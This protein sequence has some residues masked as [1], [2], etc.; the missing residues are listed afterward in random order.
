MLWHKTR[1]PVFITF[2]VRLT[3][4]KSLRP[5]SQPSLNLYASRSP[6]EELSFVW[7]NL[8]PAPRC[9]RLAYGAKMPWVMTTTWPDV[10]PAIWHLLSGT[11]FL[12]H[13][14]KAPHWQSFSARGYTMLLLKVI[15]LPVF[16]IGEPATPKW[17]NISKY[18]SYVR[19]SDVSAPTGARRKK[20]MFWGNVWWVG[21]R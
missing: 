4:Y 7:L 14:L 16:H 19:W 5:L 21:Q 18:F 13:Y 1:D 15:R 17:F 8:L 6:F 11:Q 20:S 3:A 2:K 12:E 9:I 10:V